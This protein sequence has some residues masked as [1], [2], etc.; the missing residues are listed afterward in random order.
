MTASRTRPAHENCNHTKYWLTCDQ[1]EQLLADSGNRCQAC[2]R[3]ASDCQPHQKLYID[4]DY[5]YGVWAVRGLLCPRC[6]GAF[7][8]GKTVPDWADEYFSDPWFRRAFAEMGVPIERQPEPPVGSAFK[9]PRGT[10]WIRTERCWQNQSFARSTRDWHG[11]CRD[12]SP[13]HLQHVKVATW[14]S[15]PVEVVLDPTRPAEIATLLR[16]YLSPKQ[17]E[18]VLF[19]L[20]RD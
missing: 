18:E 16:R 1:Y 7:V 13:L 20:G 4:H 15:R 5:D 3:P 11:M 8:Q 19:F 9:S 12:F 6:N 2:G 17:R 10:T 14:T